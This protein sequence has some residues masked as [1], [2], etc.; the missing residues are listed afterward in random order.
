MA[1]RAMLSLRGDEDEFEAHYMVQL[2]ARLSTTTDDLAVEVL[3]LWRSGALVEGA[4]LPRTGKD[5]LLCRAG[6]EI[7]G[8]IVARD[9]N[10]CTVEFEEEM[11]EAD[12]LLWARPSG[13]DGS[14]EAA[15]RFR[16]PDLTSPPR[17]VNVWKL[18]EIRGYSCGGPAFDD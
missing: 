4:G 12:L 17:K 6:G 5:V 14:S 18:S 9:G 8:T 3:E 2:S 11:D 1:S 15:P 7:F 10:C 13:R 16:R